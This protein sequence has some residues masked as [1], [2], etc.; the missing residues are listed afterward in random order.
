MFDNLFSK[1]FIAVFCFIMII[2]LFFLYSPYSSDKL[3]ID[4]VNQA[5]ILKE[6][7]LYYGLNGYFSKEDL[8][9]KFS[10]TFNIVGVKEDGLELLSSYK[11]KIRVYWDKDIFAEIDTVSQNSVIPLKSII[12]T[13]SFLDDGMPNNGLIFSKDGKY[14]SGCVIMIK[15]R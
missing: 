6:V 4:F 9:K 11:T 2:G 13:D 15:N 3:H 8:L 12:E 14:Y 5:R 7:I 1:L 10:E